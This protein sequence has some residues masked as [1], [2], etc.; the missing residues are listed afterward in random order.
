MNYATKFYTVIGLGVIG[1]GVLLKPVF[2]PSHSS[3]TTKPELRYYSSTDEAA[4][5]LGLNRS[6]QTTSE[7]GDYGDY[8]ESQRQRKNDLAY[9]RQNPEDWSCTDGQYR[10]Q[11]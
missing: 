3:S 6:T 4:R 8:L 2:F 7:G 10:G 5:A 9:C 11:Y 1:L